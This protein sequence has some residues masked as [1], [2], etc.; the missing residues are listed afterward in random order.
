M[1]HSNRDLLLTICF[2]LGVLGLISFF[3]GFV[4]TGMT[5]A[6]RRSV[7]TQQSALASALAADLDGLL[8]DRLQTLARIAATVPPAALADSTRAQ[9]FLRESQAAA[10]VF[11][12]GLMLISATGRLL[13]RHPD[14]DVACPL[15]SAFTEES[16]RKTVATREPATS[17]YPNPA[18]PPDLVFVA[19]IPS[20]E[21]P[22]A[23][24]VA[25]RL[26]PDTE[27]RFT[28]LVA[29]PVG[30][31]G[32]VELWSRD[33]MLLMGGTDATGRQ[34]SLP[35]SGNP[36]LEAAMAGNNGTAETNRPDGSMDLV[37]ATQLKAVPWIVIVVSPTAE[38]YAV[39]A[40]IRRNT[41][42]AVLFTLLA[43]A[44][45][46]TI[47]VR[48]MRHDLLV[49]LQQQNAL[50]NARRRTQLIL[51]SIGEGVYGAN[52][53]GN[54]TFAN[55]AA[56]QMTGWSVEELLGKSQHNVLHHT[57][58]DGSPYPIEECS[59]IAVLG[60][61]LVRRGT[62]ELF[63]RKDGTTFPIEYVSAPIRESGS[64][65]G[66]VVV[67]RDIEERRR[68]EIRERNRNRILESLTKGSSLSGV[69]R[70]IAES[71]EEED[72]SIVCS[73]LLLNESRA[74][75]QLGAAPS[76]PPDYADVVNE[77]ATDD[78]DSCCFVAARTGQR[79]IVPDAREAGGSPDMGGLARRVGMASCWAEP[80]LAAS[81]Q[82]LGSF[83]VY[84]RK[85]CSPD[86]EELR[87]IRYAADLTAL[88]V[89]YCRAFDRVQMLS[90]AVEEGSACVVVTDRAGIIEY[91]NPSFCQLTGFTAE[92]ALGQNP[93]ILKSGVHS[94]AF[95]S[96]MWSTLLSGKVWRGELCNRKKN[97]E[98][99]WELASISSLRDVAGEITHFVA[100]K[101]N[102]TDRKRMEQELQRAKESAEAANQAKGYFVANVSHEIRTPLNAIIGLSALALRTEM[103]ARQQDYVGKIHNAG[104]SLL[105]II[106]DILDFSK[107]ESGKLQLEAVDFDLEDV[108]TNVNTLTGRKARER[109]LEVLF[110]VSS[111][112]PASLTGDPLRLGQVLVNLMSNAAKFTEKGEIELSVKLLQRTGDELKVGFA[113]R[114]TG[115]GMTPEQAA[116]LFQPFTQADTSTTRKYGGTGLGLSISR[117]LVEM[118]G[119][120][121]TV[122]SDPG[123]G[124]TFRFTARLRARSEA[125]QQIDA[126][127]SGIKGLRVLV[128]DDQASVQQVLARIL[129]RI[130]S[131]VTTV[132]NGR[133]AVDAVVRAPAS[134]PYDVLLTDWM[135]PVLDGIETARQVRARCGSSPGPRIILMTGYDE[136]LDRETAQAAGVDGFLFKPV[137]RSTLFDEL[138]R[139]FVARAESAQDAGAAR[140]EMGK[141]LRGARILLAEDNEINQQIAVELL[142]DAGASVDVAINGRVALEKLQTSP[143][144]YDLVL[145]DIQMPE[146][147]GHETSR[148]IRA[149]GRFADLPII[150]LTAHALG[151]EK[152]RFRESGMADQI[153]KPIDPVAMFETL[154]RWYRPG[155][156][157]ADAPAP[158]RAGTSPAPDKMPQ[159]EG[160]DTVAGLERVAGNAGLY[161]SL[162]RR[163]AETRAG[164]ATDMSDAMEK[165]DLE[166]ARQ[167][168]HT[169][170]GLAGNLGATTVEA[171]AASLEIAFRGNDPEAAR[172][173]LVR[174]S[175]ELGRI[176]GRIAS[177]LPDVPGGTAGEASQASIPVSLG[178]AL[179]ELARQLKASNLESLECF[180]RL[181]EDLSRS[182]PPEEFS[183]LESSLRACDFDSALQGVEKLAQR[184][185]IA[186]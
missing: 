179:G 185:G 68:V 144:S 158:D 102:L 75:L 160:V 29:T 165:R 126:Y 57:K 148:R 118:M 62:D 43:S 21:G 134:E 3:S 94:A 163:F 149:D 114:D 80:V 127:S 67:F 6:V 60:D 22:V 40:H 117:R 17:V 78:A 168:A 23:G 34:R 13:A 31:D 76:L 10:A 89:E 77:A 150:A 147:D 93:R 70:A 90:R 87:L 128:A 186:I 16:F 36:V 81:G 106:N 99:Y 156:T 8:R 162:L 19:P 124:S 2:S 35:G 52:L 108:L 46:L 28:H 65:T 55:P 105:V 98:F 107:I 18:G 161:A 135:M 181:R 109:G 7:Q 122:E 100:V 153:T 47:I 167:L 112:V 97:G 136:E 83:A 95:Y 157:I 121:L 50:E 133:A 12:A 63:W 176:V 113:V 178:S 137:T 159:I 82:P 172:A 101:E 69:L 92:E 73:I 142:G 131:K 138:S 173:P 96:E 58:R 64:V 125:I 15:P 37:S 56:A 139:L 42:S 145:M 111:Q 74:R 182:C 14:T 24:L 154:R 72:P 44:I 132:G 129:G 1:Q 91:V 115:M 51:E 54:V 171:A 48:R 45:S 151:E 116:T 25:A 152:L 119:G 85:P 180:D 104:T 110:D 71:V 66:A 49:R 184:L 86:A 39:L 183:L 4:M 33:R 53:E 169:V 41:T 130:E 143:G 26:D 20:P 11:P 5:T 175:E 164:T 59:I 30:R 177:A 140:Q 9:G 84:H 141:P 120:E 79:A 61:S 155:D 32:H 170:K 146:M 103:T 123:K 174:F 88:A 27:S 38:A 166:R